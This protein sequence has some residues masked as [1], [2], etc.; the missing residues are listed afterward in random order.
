MAFA[1][2]PVAVELYRESQIPKRF[3]PASIAIGAFTFTM[4][5]LPGTPQIQNAI[6][7]KFLGRM[8][9]LHLF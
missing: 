1:V 6:P 8:C 3:I 9:M 2:Y 4:T 7:M 5:A